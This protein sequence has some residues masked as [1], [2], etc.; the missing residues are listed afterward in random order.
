MVPSTVTSCL[1]AVGMRVHDRTTRSTHPTRNSRRGP[2]SELHAD[3]GADGPERLDLL[4]AGVRRVPHDVVRDVLLRVKVA[5]GLDEETSLR[6]HAVV[7]AE[8][9]GERAPRGRGRVVGD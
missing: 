5:R 6:R 1:G 8:S 3:P 4:V 9:R 7:G 2:T